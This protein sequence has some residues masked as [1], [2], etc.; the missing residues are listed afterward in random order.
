MS[1]TYRSV[2]HVPGG[3]G[4]ADLLGHRHARLNRTFESIPRDIVDEIILVD[5]WCRNRERG[6]RKAS[7][8]DP[9][10]SRARRDISMR[11]ECR[12]GSRRC[13]RTQ[14]ED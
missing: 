2:Q 8:E 5:G 1:R 10:R 3:G 12:P 14:E 11:L 4:A 7:L 9:R 13:G 6:Q